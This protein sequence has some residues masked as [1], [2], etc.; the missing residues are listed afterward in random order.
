MP[1]SHRDAATNETLVPVVNPQSGG[2]RARRVERTDT[3]ASALGWW[4]AGGLFALLA[5]ANG[6]GYRFGVSDQAF[7]IPVVARALDPAAFP[8]DAALIDAQG[9]LMATDEILASIA[10]ASGLSLEL[11]FLGGYLLSLAIIWAGLVLVGTRVYRSTWV[12]IALGAAFTLRHRIPRTSANSF[13]PYFHPRMLA[14][15]VGVLA[16]AA[17][18]RRRRWMAV[19]LVAAAA[20]IHATTA[21]WFAVLIGT[22]MLVLDP[23]LRPAAWVAAAVACAAGGWLVLGGPLRAS[24]VRMDATWLE[25]VATKDSLFLDQW[26]P[27]AW[28]A[29]LGLLAV[30]WWA[31]RRRAQRGEASAEDA[32]LVWGATALVALV[33]LTWPLVAARLALPVQ[34]QITRVFWL[35]DFVALLYLLALVDRP[36]ERAA[37]VVAALLVAAAAA[38]GIYIMTV[39]RPERPLFAVRLPDT[40]WQDAM[41]WVSRQPLDVHILADPGH[42]W[43]YDTSVRV[44]ARRDVFLEDVKDSAIAIYSR[45]VAARVVERRAAVGDFGSL[46]ADRAHELAAAYDL[47]YLV[48]ESEL[49]LPAVYRNTRFRIYA[50]A[51]PGRVVD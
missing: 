39:E 46:T 44:S 49:P 8:R 14:F 40:P 12:T 26:P 3:R 16:V 43:M 2:G 13:E 30:L 1:A 15:A 19:G 24:L 4:L 10:R 22:A 21:L 42:A 28:A 7:Y 32:A 35:V 33:L 25:A 20:V 36:G 9:R 47:D 29:N 48:T 50:L 18:L 17:L 38:R 5:T 45:E 6:A 37:R 27:W 11:L 51:A 34:L 31:H 23:R 41:R